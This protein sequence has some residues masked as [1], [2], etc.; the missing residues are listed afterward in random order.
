MRPTGSPVRWR[1]RTL[2][3][4]ACCL[5]LGLLAFLSLVP[6]AITSTNRWVRRLGFVRWKRLH[7]LSYAA[8]ILG[9][10]HFTWRV[11]ADLREPIV[12]AA[13]LAVLF[14]VRISQTALTPP[15]IGA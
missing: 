2:V 9:V 6:L 8:A 1:E 4:A 11:K 5:P 7:R 10:V 3:F 14:A 12:F 15:R 13:V